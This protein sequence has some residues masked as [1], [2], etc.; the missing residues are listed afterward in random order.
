MTRRDVPARAR[1]RSSA[2]RL[3]RRRRARALRPAPRRRRDRPEGRARRRLERAARRAAARD[4]ARRHR[5]LP[6][7][8]GI[9]KKTA[10]AHR[11]RAEGLDRR[12]DR[13]GVEP[14]HRASS[15]RATRSSSSA[16]RSSRPSRRSRA[17]I[18]TA[19]RG[20]R[21]RSAAERGMTTRAHVP[22]TGAPGGRRGGRA[23]AAPAPARR[24]RRAGADRRSSS[25]SRS[26]P[27]KARGDALDHVLLV[28]PPGLG[29]TTLATIIREE[30][31]VGIRTVAGP[32]A[33]AE[34]RHGRDPHGPRAARRPV[35]RRDPPDQPRDRGD[36]VPG[37]RGLPAR[38]HRRPG[39]RRANAHARPCRR[40]RSSARRRAP[41]C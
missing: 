3:R 2:L 30:L 37:A 33:R 18:R 25:T 38:H 7:D 10:R 24:L 14:G 31:G 29:K 8:P 35:R 13:A 41:A 9:G 22:R 21:P 15:S 16:T 6:G 27:R 12:R 32:G 11:P 4:R 34:G 5:P 39:R 20:A 17:S 28:G 26:R 1:R 19:G 23:V 40:S 36:P